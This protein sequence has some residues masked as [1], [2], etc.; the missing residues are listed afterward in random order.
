MAALVEL[1]AEQ[2]YETT[3][4]SDVVKRAAVARKTLYD[5]FAGKEDVFLAAFDGAV[6]EA[7][8]RVEEACGAVDGDLEKAVE[9]G[10]GAFLAYVAEEPALAQACVIEAHCASPATAKRYEDA[11]EE[12][13]EMA[14]ERLPR[15]PRLPETIEETLVGGIA[16]IVNQQ[17]RRGGAEQAMELLPELCEFVLAP[18]RGAGLGEGA[19]KHG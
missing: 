10:L 12:I 15:D 1:T 19:D 8:R 11:V 7:T 4:I 16:W 3:K 9:A 13:V 2:G 5:N 14:R 17:I 18:Y 6:E